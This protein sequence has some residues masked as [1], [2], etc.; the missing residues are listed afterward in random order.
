MRSTDAPVPRLASPALQES[1][2]RIL[3]R[4]ELFEWLPIDPRHDAGH[5]P[6]RLA[7]LD[8]DNQRALLIKGRKGSAEVVRPG[9]GDAP[10]G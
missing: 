10:Q 7:H 3:V 2:K 8:L 4:V 1:Q 5:Q 6:A 9:H